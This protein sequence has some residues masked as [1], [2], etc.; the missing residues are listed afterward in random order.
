MG[1]ENEI[2]PN[3][4]EQ[5]SSSQDEQEAGWFL[6]LLDAMALKE[7]E[8]ELTKIIGNVIALC[9]GAIN[10]G[11]RIQFQPKEVPCA[12]YA[13]TEALNHVRTAQGLISQIYYKDQ[14]VFPL[15]I[16]LRFASNMNL[17]NGE[18]IKEKARRMA[19]L[20]QRFTTKVKTL[21]MW[22]ITDID[23]I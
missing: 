10:M 7:L 9:Y 4:Q 23:M 17:L 20:Q 12:V 6:W 22:N 11:K 13:E 3:L 8:E 5:H 16:K 19:Y 18:N 15:G 21:T 1:S 2:G 14:T